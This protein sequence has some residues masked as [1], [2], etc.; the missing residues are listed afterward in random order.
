MGNLEEFGVSSIF[1]AWLY[2]WQF[3][4][5][6]EYLERRQILHTSIMEPF[7]YISSREKVCL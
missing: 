4:S 6:L 5:A 1:Q 3:S 7:I 2:A